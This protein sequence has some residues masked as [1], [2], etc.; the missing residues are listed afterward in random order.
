LSAQYLIRFDDLCPTMNWRVW[1]KIES[2]LVEHQITPLL[3]VVPDNRDHKL[4]VAP[5]HSA[6]W[7]QVRTWQ[8]RGW[9]IGLHGYQHT[10]LTDNGGIVG[11]QRRSEFAGLSA[12]VQEEKLRKAVEIFRHEA[13]EP[14]VWIAPGHS[15]DWNTVEALKKVGI[16][17]ISDGFALAPHTD[18]RGVF[19]IP[20]QLWKFRWRPFGLWTVCCHPNSWTEQNISQ[21]RQAIREYR[22]D[23]TDFSTVTSAYRKRKH[24]P[25]D[26]LYAKAHSTLLF[27]RNQLQTAA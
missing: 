15:F 19:W 3:A 22:P 6:F 20:Q 1:A 7:E 24:G 25:M 9:T 27:L 13:I 5:A 2:I 14:K 11:I 26:S 18:S 8:A 16:V 10:Y 23:I 12:K 17:T 4:A 21:F